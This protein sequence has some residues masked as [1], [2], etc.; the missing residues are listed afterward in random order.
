MANHI[1]AVQRAFTILDALADAEETGL[2]L[3]EVSKNTGI[4]ASTAHHIIATLINQHMAEQD[5]HSKR[6]LLGLHIIELGQAAIHSTGFS[7]ISGT[8]AE[9]LADITGQTTNLI[10]FRGL[11]RIRILEA[12]RLHIIHIRG[13]TYEIQDLHA[14]GSGKLLLAHLPPVDYAKYLSQTKLRQYLANT[15]TNPEELSRELEQIRKVGYAEDREEFI[16]GVRAI[17]VPI[18]D[19]TERVRGALDIIFP[20]FTIQDGEIERWITKACQIA[21][22]LSQQLLAIGR[23]I[24]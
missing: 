22:E 12:Q 7:Q 20:S 6:Y 17:T 16:S 24:Y 21:S 2:T 15:I 23:V 19:A 14:T 11:H 10:I 3:G 1:Q 8:Y 4:N 5:P 9:R 18:Y 13:V